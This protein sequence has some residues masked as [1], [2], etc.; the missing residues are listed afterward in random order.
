MSCCGTRP[1]T[2]PARCHRVA[3][4][5]A[6]AAAA[7]VVW[8]PSRTRIADVHDR[9]SDPMWSERACAWPSFWAPNGRG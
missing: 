6:L 7:R 5:P 4:S 2:F 9:V 8:P 1:R 3:G